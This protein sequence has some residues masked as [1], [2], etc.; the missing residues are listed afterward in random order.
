MNGMSFSARGSKWANSALVVGVQTESVH[1]LAAGWED[2]TMP[3]GQET[4]V[5]V[6][7]QRVR[8]ALSLRRS[9]SGP[10]WTGVHAE[11]LPPGFT[12]PPGVTQ[13]VALGHVPKTLSASDP[14][15]PHCKL[16]N[17]DS[18]RG[19]VAINRESPVSSGALTQN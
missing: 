4:L 10:E 5:G 7:F 18:R 9:I 12:S 17:V 1:Q 16:T 6:E 14:A 15:S 3:E 2:L 19:W 11:V 8:S 13:R